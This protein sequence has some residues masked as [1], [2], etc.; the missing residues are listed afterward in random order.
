MHMEA[1]RISDSLS[2][3]KIKLAYK[4]NPDFFTDYNDVDSIWRFF[5]TQKP[6]GHGWV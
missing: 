6:V 4:E 3:D 5:E 1:Q 2:F